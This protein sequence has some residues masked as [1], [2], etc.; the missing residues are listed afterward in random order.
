MLSDYSYVGSVN[1][2]RSMQCQILDIQSVG[3]IGAIDPTKMPHEGFFVGT[4][5]F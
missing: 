1:L 4:F 2:L 3:Y 5:N